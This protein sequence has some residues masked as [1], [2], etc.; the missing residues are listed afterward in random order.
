MQNLQ[1]FK[2][3]CCSGA[4]EWNS[5]A[6]KMKCPYCETEFEMEAINALN[7]SA[8]AEQPDDI[9]WDTEAGEQWS[10]GEAQ[11]MAVYVCE[12]CGA[13]IVTDQ[14]TA[15]TTCPYCD[16]N[17]VMR[18]NLAG[19]LKP[20]LVIPFKLDKKAAKEGFYNHLKGKRLLPKIFKD[21][22]HIDEI[23]G[24]YVPFWLFDADANANIKYLATRISTWSD[25]EYI[26]EKTSYYN[27]LRGGSLSFSNIPADGSSQMDDALMDSIE[28]FN[29]NEA[30]DF[31]TAYLS[32]YLADKYDVSADDNIERANL[33]IKNSTEEAFRKTVQGYA[34]VVK[35]SS[36][37]STTNG[38]TKYALFPVWI[39]NTTYQGQ[40]YTFAMNGQTG[41]FV[42]N[43]PI[44]KKTFFKY[45]GLSFAGCSVVASL[46]SYL[47][48]ML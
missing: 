20:D 47:V 13:E 24:V 9:K 34:T 14:T 31:N 40:K 5:N 21:E 17:I 22:N 32:G 10:G 37:V 23:K 46:I 4:I 43:L 12:S 35:Q 27:I 15:A 39:L 3:P 19:E 28:P 44:C 8:M 25:S 33:R 29:M 38:K 45:L 18:G 6:Q 30:V 41:K 42:G 2:C 16:N 26:Y 1:D 11:N 48:M 7:E 36:S